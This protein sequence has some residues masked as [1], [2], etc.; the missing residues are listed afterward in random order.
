[1]FG[2]IA[3]E[4]EKNES[5]QQSIVQYE[6]YNGSVHSSLSLKASTMPLKKRAKHLSDHYKTMHGELLG[7]AK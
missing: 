3:R 6:D 4:E 5:I 1:M 7:N 2:T